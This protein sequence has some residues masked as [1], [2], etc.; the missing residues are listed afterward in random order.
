MIMPFQPTCL[1]TWCWWR[2]SIQQ[3]T[4]D[5]KS[6]SIR[7]DVAYSNLEHNVYGARLYFAFD[8]RLARYLS[9]CCSKCNGPLILTS[10]LI[11]L[12]ISISKII[13]TLVIWSTS[14]VTQRRL[15]LAEPSFSSNKIKLNKLNVLTYLLIYCV[16]LS[17]V[18][19]F[20]FVHILRW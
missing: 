6:L 15:S 11:L 3:P 10:V 8:P 9:I 14:E 16:T 13:M 20:L 2:D 19:W 12:F 5:W 17:N 1:H 18:R 7:L 4:R